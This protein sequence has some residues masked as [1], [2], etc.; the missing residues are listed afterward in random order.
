MKFTQH[1][2]IEKQLTE[3]FVVVYSGR[4]QPFHSNHYQAYKDLTNKFGSDRV[5]IATSNKIDN[6][7]SPFSFEEKKSI[8]VN[9]FNIPV[10]MIVETES[11]YKPVELFNRI[12]EPHLAYIT[13]L[14]KKDSER[15]AGGK[16]FVPY[17]EDK[18]LYSHD[19]HG[20]V[21]IIPDKSTTFDGQ[22]ISGSLVRKI[23]RSNDREIKM[24]LFMSIYPKFDKSIFELF[25]NTIK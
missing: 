7:L 23:F 12:H 9:L 2:L 8:M 20:Y 15:L 4:F 1:Y 13:A 14:G 11:P 19:S 18:A 22:L 6:V 10:E 24:R 5:Y 3:E 16:Y 25:I 17:N 21:Y